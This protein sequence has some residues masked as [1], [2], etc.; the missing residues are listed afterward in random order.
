MLTII[1]TKIDYL[2]IYVKCINKK[3]C[4]KVY[5]RYGSGGILSNREEGRISHCD[6]KAVIIAV[7]TATRRP[8]MIRG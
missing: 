4:K 2:Y 6:G 3:K 8:F 5:H 7:T 1:S